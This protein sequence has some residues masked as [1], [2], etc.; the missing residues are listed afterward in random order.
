MTEARWIAVGVYA[1]V[2]GA[3]LLISLLTHARRNAATRKR[4]FA[5]LDHADVNGYFA[6]GEWLDGATVHDIAYD[7]TLYA[8][9][10]EDLDASYL[11]P[12]VQEWLDRRGRK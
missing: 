3:I 6:K 8:A 5:N 1:M 11:V 12:Y 2:V 4:V 7:M 10:C 9:D